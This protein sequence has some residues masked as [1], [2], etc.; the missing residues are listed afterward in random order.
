MKIDS[1]KMVGIHP[2]FKAKPGKMQKIQALLPAFIA[3]TATE[4]GNLF[5]DFT[6]H[7][8]QLFCREAYSGAAAAL[9]HLDNVASLLGDLMKLADLT[10]LEVHG[11]GAEL[12]KLKSPMK[13][14][15]P[16]WF[17]RYRAG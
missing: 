14:L 7:E 2:Y 5:Y 11:P 3:K 4:K 13:D 15:N 8:D 6:I 12:E 16:I 10:R 17:T 9:G 1:S